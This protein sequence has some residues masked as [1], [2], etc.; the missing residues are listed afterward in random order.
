MTTAAWQRRSRAFNDD[1][2]ILRKLV[3]DTYQIDTET[4]S[5]NE[6]LFEKTYKLG[7]LPKKEIA[8]DIISSAL[9]LPHEEDDLQIPNSIETPRGDTL[10]AQ[11]QSLLTNNVTEQERRS[12]TYA[13]SRIVT[14]RMP[15][16][17]RWPIIPEGLDTLTAALI[18]LYIF[19][20]AVNQKIPWIVAIWKWKIREAKINALV[21]INDKLVENPSISEIVSVLQDE[22]Q[23]FIIAINLVP[24]IDHQDPFSLQISKWKDLLL[25]AAE[26][27]K[28]EKAAEKEQQQKKESENKNENSLQET[29][30]KVK[31]EVRKLIARNKAYSLFLTKEKDSTDYAAT[32]WNLLALRADGPPSKELESLLRLLRKEFNILRFDPIRKLCINLAHSETPG[33][34]TVEDLEQVSDFSGRNAYYEM[35]RLESLFDEY[36]ILNMAKFGLRY[37]YIFTEL[38]KSGVTSDGLIEKLHFNEEQISGCTIHIE[39]NLSRGPDLQVFSGDYFEAV[40]EQEIVTLNLNH[41]DVKT[42][43]WLIAQQEEISDTKQKDSLLIQRS[44]ETNDKNPFSVTTS[45]TEFLSLIWSLH[46][47]RSQRKWYLD[48]VNYN[49]QT[50]TRN[51]SRMLRN[52]AI[53]LL[54][55]PSLEFCG[56]PDGLVVFANCNDRKSRDRLVNHIIDSQPFSQIRFG[57][58]NDVVA[59][60]RSP[61]KDSGKVALFLKQRMGEFS[62]NYMTARI[63]ERKTYKIT[64]LQKLFQPKT[65]TWKDPW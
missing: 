17:I 9:G 40:T 4:Q 2:P 13:L 1:A 3:R 53:R 36:Y 62:D 6:S 43:D 41:F 15:R 58:T 35:L 25:E 19:S 18:Q 20:K 33:H 44:T 22:D 16:K 21:T 37:R 29:L 5:L 48:A 30:A 34:P 45:Q 24:K 39:P 61:F 57:D 46:G 14:Q 12:L 54:Y 50:A 60:I 27:E 47:V 55:L 38:Q 51:L 59:Q 64:C 56:L 26:R 42:G 63:Q 31:R 65:R 8:E 7:T 52:H 10:T 32:N 23:K 11:I 49:Q 28:N